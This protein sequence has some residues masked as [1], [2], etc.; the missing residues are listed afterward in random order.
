MFNVP[1]VV[2][3][4]PVTLIPVPAVAATLVTVP[5]GLVAQEVLVPS[6][7]RY[8]PELP[9]WLGA[10]ALNDALAVICPVPPDA[11]GRA[12][13]K[14]RSLADIER[15]AV[16]LAADT[17]DVIPLC[18]IGNTSVPA[19]GV[20]AA[21]KADIFTFAI[22]YSNIPLLKVTYSYT[23]VAVIVPLSTI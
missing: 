22:V 21:G 11:I 1:L 17:L 6:V 23:T 15:P 19:N 16:K 3:G 2:I 9:V 14:V 12:L 13:V 5:S 4:L 10:N 18:T 8:L 7:V 20:V